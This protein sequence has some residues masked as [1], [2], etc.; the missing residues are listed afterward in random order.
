MGCSFS[1]PRSEKHPQSAPASLKRSY[2]SEVE[3]GVGNP[4]TWNWDS[5]ASANSHQGGLKPSK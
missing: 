1:A 2:V 4:N 5:A 3:Q